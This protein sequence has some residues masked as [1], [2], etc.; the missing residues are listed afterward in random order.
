M[1]LYF[2]CLDMGGYQGKTYGSGY[3]GHQQLPV[4]NDVQICDG[5]RGFG[6]R[7]AK[8]GWP[9]SSRTSVETSDRAVARAGVH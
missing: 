6:E 5:I 7:F 2:Q 1:F 3:G 9:W 8:E 4:L